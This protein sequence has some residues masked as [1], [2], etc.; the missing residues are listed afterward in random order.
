MTE[1]GR[2]KLALSAGVPALIL[3]CDRV[4]K[5]LAR[6]QLQDEPAYKAIAVV[7][8]LVYLSWVTNRVGP[9]GTFAGF[10][11]DANRVFFV[12]LAAVFT[13]YLVWLL[14]RATPEHRPSLPPIALLLG[15]VLGNALDRV[16]HGEVIDFLVVTL[17]E[18]SWGRFGLNIADIAIAAA[19]VWL[20]AL[21][22]RRP[23]GEATAGSAA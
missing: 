2:Y 5:E 15:G 8:D 13:A 18:G 9:L 6:L 3:I 11:A 7:P 1:W 21:R 10:G 4:T 12:A 19:I 22:F 17:S 20:I 16:F 14:V 23:S